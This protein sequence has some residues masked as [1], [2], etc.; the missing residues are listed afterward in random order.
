MMK[1]LSRLAQDAALL[2]ARLVAGPILVAHGWQR[3]RG[4]LD[5]Q[6][7]VLEAA[8]IG[9]PDLIVLAVLV[10]EVLGGIFLTFGLATRPIGLGIVVLNV[11]IVFTTKADAGLYLTNGG[12]EYNAALAALGF[13]LLGLGSGRA[14]VDHLFKRPKHDDDADLIEADGDAAN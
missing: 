2:V 4:G 6:Q 9:S 14:G 11:A 10:F 7:A 1:S 5:H 8:G 12:W 13:V 3:W